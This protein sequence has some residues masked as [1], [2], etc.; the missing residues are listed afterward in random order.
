MTDRLSSL[1]KISYKSVQ[2]FRGRCVPNRQS[3][4]QTVNLVFRHNHGEMR[5]ISKLSVMTVSVVESNIDGEN[6]G[7]LTIT[8]PPSFVN[9]R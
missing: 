7:Q 5:D 6:V 4:R 2:Q 3:H 9:E 8:F 1:C